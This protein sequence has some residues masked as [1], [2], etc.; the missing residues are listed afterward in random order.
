MGF[1]PMQILGLIGGG[2]VVFIL[3]NM[4]FTAYLAIILFVPIVY[5]FIIKG[6]KIYK[7]QSKGCPNYMDAMSIK[8]RCPSYIIDASNLFKYL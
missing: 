4:L 8:E 6:K 1:S 2:L 5:Y 3:L 7:E